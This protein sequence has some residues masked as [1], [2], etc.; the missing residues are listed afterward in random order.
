MRRIGN[1]ITKIAS[2][3][4]LLAS[5]HHV[6]SGSDAQT[7]T[8]KYLITHKEDILDKLQKE[9]L[10][11]KY[12]LTEYQEFERKELHKIRR[13]QCVP[14]Y[15]RIALHAISTVI[16]EV[17]IPTFIADTAASLKGRGGL[18]LFNRMRKDMEKD[19]EGTKYVY[20]CDISKC[21]QSIDQDKMMKVI[22][23]KI[24]DKILLRILNGIVHFMAEGVAIGMRT[25]QVLVNL[26]LSVYFDHPMKEGIQFKYFRRYCDDMV[27]QAGSYEELQRGIDLIHRQAEAAG[28]KI[29]PNEQRWC[30]DNRCI[31]FLG[32]RIYASGKI[33]LRKHIVHRFC[34]RW[35]RVRSHSRR[36]KLIG[37]FYG[38]AKHSNS[39]NLLIKI[40]HRTMQQFADFGITYQ[41]KNGKRTFDCRVVSIT[42]LINIPII[43]LDF[44]TDIHT[45]NGYRT[46]VQVKIIETGEVVKYFTG[47]DEMT[48][49]LEAVRE[50]FS[51]PFETKLVRKSYGE[52]WKLMFS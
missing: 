44:E 37:S 33:L 36:V 5:F 3:E 49:A 34:K 4:N 13:I 31:D 20:K 35:H 32:Y 30:I 43:V 48:K 19:P 50:N 47:G 28:L 1:L 38:F 16:E 23:S 18:Y 26:Y 17:L 40:I 22:E 21:Y 12:H 45:N 10:T 8:G 27:L 11:G 42:D 39:N 51:F 52:H 29:K 2:Q 14:F 9:L 25:S 41:F 24:K 15:D 46:L 7:K 6:L